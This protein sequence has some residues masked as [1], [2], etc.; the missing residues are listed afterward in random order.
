MKLDP[1]EI[2]AIAEALAPKVADIL[3]RRFSEQPQWA[4]SV[5]EAA[6]WAEVEPH[7]IR[8]AISDGRLPAVRIGRQVR[9]R[10]SDLF[11][12]RNGNGEAGGADKEVGA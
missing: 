5:A 4:L 7:V 11:A 12:V 10:R 2:A 6:S 9:I 1:D 3:E 8:D